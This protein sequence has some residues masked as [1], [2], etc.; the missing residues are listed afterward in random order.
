M[1]LYLAKCKV[2]LGYR[3]RK[4]NN[5]FLPLSRARILA[6]RTGI[7]SLKSDQGCI[8][9]SIV[10]CVLSIVRQD[11]GSQTYPQLPITP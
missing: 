10:I 11:M 5:N 6:A 7:P 9:D 3:N 8:V 4:D 1:S 2:T